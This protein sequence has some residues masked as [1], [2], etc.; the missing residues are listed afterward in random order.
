MEDDYQETLK[1]K[2]KILFQLGKWQD[3]SKLC[4]Q[5][6][7]T[8][9]KDAEIDLMRFKSERQQSKSSSPEASPP[10]NKPAQG[11]KPGTL[12]SSKTSDNKAEEEQPILLTADI[13]SVQSPAMLILDEVALEDEPQ[14][15]EEKLDYEPFPQANELIITDPY[16]ENEPKIVDPSTENEEVLSLDYNDPPPAENMLV[17]TDPFTEDSAEDAADEPIIAYP[18]T[19]DEPKFHLPGNEPPLILDES[20]QS[21]PVEARQEIQAEDISIVE[22][23]PAEPAQSGSSYDFQSNPA[24]TIDVEPELDSAA[25]EKNMADMPANDEEKKTPA[26]PMDS[27]SLHDEKSFDSW[28]EPAAATVW[29]KPEEPLRPMRATDTDLLNKVKSSK[30]FVFNFKYL[31]VLILPLAAAVVSWL[32]LSG[33]LTSDGDASVKESPVVVSEPR[34]PPVRKAVPKVPPLAPV[35]KIDEKERL[36]NEKILQAEKLF[37]NGDVLNA[38]AVVLEA[39][40][41]KITEPLSQLERLITNKIRDDK[42]RE[43]EQ[44]E[45]DLRLSQS[46]E[47]VFAKADAENTIESWRNFLLQYPQ[48]VFA[49]RARNKMVA[50]EKKALL[51]A[52]QELQIKIR[53]AKKLTLRSNYLNINQAEL[54]AALQQLGKPSVQFEQLQRGAEKV[55]VD[56]SSG[57]MWFL[58]TKPMAFDKASWW[59][60]R[61]YAGYSG[62]R[63]PTVEESQSLLRMDRAIYA[64]LSDFTVWT[65][66]GVSDKARSV[67]ALKLLSGQF[68]PENNEQLYYVW[69]VRKAV[70]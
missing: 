50:L 5:Y 40:K 2:I 12:E 35:P 42:L 8:Y 9:G 62:W 16:A 20:S 49:A 56:F 65:G 70:R 55:I 33:K 46:E 18:G 51:Q 6:L 59:A 44:K 57:L 14:S 23:I 61:N 17:I 39:K 48:S 41:I 64:G 34:V 32:A 27:D 7:E 1:G 21:E 45:A 28:N 29:E 43:A 52:E 66:D 60:N 22:D 19:E 3:V 38:L 67:W 68:S 25:G 63:L 54:N 37:K 53:Q 69:A 58:Y 11:Q 10:L 24:A 15:A 13:E 30:K 47:Q 4:K 31:L 26:E 36:V